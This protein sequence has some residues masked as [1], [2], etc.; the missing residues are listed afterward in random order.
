MFRI[1]FI[2]I[3][4]L[5]AGNVSAQEA[6]LLLQN[7]Q[8]KF[9]ET[10][11]FIADFDQRSNSEIEDYSY[12]L[13]GAIYFKKGNQFKLELKEQE[14]I[15]DGYTVWNYD[16]SKNR[17]VISPYEDEMTAFSLDMFIFEFPE[18]SLLEAT[19]DIE[20]AYAGLVLKSNSNDT[21]FT[22]IKLFVDE[23]FVVKIIE[24]TDF[25]ET[26]YLINL[27]NIRL[28]AGLDSGI[29]NFEPP[30]GTKIVDLR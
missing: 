5:L 2:L 15:S 9:E 12:R 14:I 19:R 27:F 22:E 8:Q 10:E 6:E 29:F 26:K 30:E 24:I 3:L 16:K 17:V 25:S 11:D 28:N 1:S 7:I 13:Q 21:N 4:L 23:N 18:K 20:T